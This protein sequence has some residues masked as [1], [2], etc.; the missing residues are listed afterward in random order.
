[1]LVTGA[2]GR[3]GGILRAA[4]GDDAAIWQSRR[5]RPGYFEW[6]MLARPWSGP[7]L[8]GSVI[9]NLAG[10]TSG[11]ALDDNIAL[12]RAALD[13]GAAQGAAHLFLLSSAAVYGRGD[14]GPL[15]E[16]GPVHP[17]NPYGHSKLEMEALAAGLPHVTVLRLGNVAG[18]DALLGRAVADRVV[19]LDP[20][21]GRPG[22]PARSY[23]GPLTLA[24]VV[25]R[26]C[27]LAFAGAA[28][29]PILN[30]AQ[31]GGVTMAA[32]LDAA[33]LPWHYGP[34]NP[35]VLS[36]VLLDTSRLESLMEVPVADA[37]VMVAEWRELQRMRQA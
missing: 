37:T 4:W 26:L 6:D 29:P 34:E 9:V 27:D 7:S 30:L 18:A 14:G 2:A 8:S 32:L 12:A 1:M 23:I 24:R 16:D 13:L 10:V 15:R 19:Q 22:G 11:A 31:P 17:A 25:A 21:P 28:L 33:G 35:Q 36:S 5:S 3:I 20:V